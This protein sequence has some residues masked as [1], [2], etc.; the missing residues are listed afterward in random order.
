MLY[1][2]LVLLV[3][4]G[5]LPCCS[6]AS[7][8]VI[9]DIVFHAVSSQTVHSARSTYGPEMRHHD[10]DQRPPAQYTTTKLPNLSIRLSIRIRMKMGISVSVGNKINTK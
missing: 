10:P 4:G 8:V 2:V 9:V 5:V 7:L 6:E 1:G 3:A